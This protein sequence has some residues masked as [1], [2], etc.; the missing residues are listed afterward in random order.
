MGPTPVA[1]DVVL[2]N[3]ICLGKPLAFFRGDKRYKKPEN[4]QGRERKRTY[5]E[6]GEVDRHDHQGDDPG[7][8]RHHGADEAAE[9]A[10]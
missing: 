3:L 6:G 10:A 9:E 1:V 2:D 5:P 7:Y 8:Y 4:T